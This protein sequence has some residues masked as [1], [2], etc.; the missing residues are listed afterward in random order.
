V[1]EKA[2][3]QKMLP[4][5]KIFHAFISISYQQPKTKTLATLDYTATRGQSLNQQQNNARGQY[6]NNGGGYIVDG[7][8]I[9]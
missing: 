3:F 6:S 7:L 8:L 5:F 4:C 2:P 9:I 1:S